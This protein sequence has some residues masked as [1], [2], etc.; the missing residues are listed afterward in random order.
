MLLIFISISEKYIDKCIKSVTD[1]KD[2]NFEVHV[3]L[4]DCGDK[5]YEIAM[6]H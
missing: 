2:V 3:M 6:R 5:S 1:Q 4:D